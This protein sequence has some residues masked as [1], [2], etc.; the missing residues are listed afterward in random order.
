MST[1]LDKAIDFIR[2][3]L[4]IGGRCSFVQELVTTKLMRLRVWH[5]IVDAS[6]SKSSEFEQRI[7]DYSKSDVKIIF[8][9]NDD[10]KMQQFLIIFQLN[11]TI[12]DLF[13]VKRSKMLK[14]FK[15]DNKNVEMK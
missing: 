3:R 6:D 9:L 4:L 8:L 11:T 15:N 5:Q 2:G 14:S 10:F 12:F 1:R 7:Y 13:L